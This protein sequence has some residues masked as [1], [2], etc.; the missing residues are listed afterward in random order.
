MPRLSLSNTQQL[1]VL[2]ALAGLVAVAVWLQWRHR[3]REPFLGA[4]LGVVRTVATS[5]GKNVANDYKSQAMGVVGMVT[6][7]KPGGGQKAPA[8]QVTYTGRQFN[9]Q[10]WSCP[11]WSVETGWED[12]KACITSQFHPPAWKWTGKDWGWA[13]PNGTVP[14]SDPVWEKKC[15]VGWTARV[16][17]GGTWKCPWGTEDSGKN[18]ENSSWEE[19]HKQCR[20]S[21]PFTL[22]ISK[23]GKW[24]CPDGTTDTKRGWGQQNEWDQC[25]WTGP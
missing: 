10:E 5:V 11:W 3:N 7:K 14:T 17:D 6:G 22:R 23:D 4:I 15:E 21:R 12:S 24:V 25:K 9:G 1:L 19:A 2:A 16:N 13:C 18:W 20:R 8:Y